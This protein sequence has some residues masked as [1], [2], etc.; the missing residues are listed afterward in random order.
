MAKV[1]DAHIH[2]FYGNKED[3]KTF[4]STSPYKDMY[5]AY[6][7]VNFDYLNV[8]SYLSDIFGAFLMPFI[9][10]ETD[11]SNTNKTLFEYVRCLSSSIYP[12]PLI[13]EVNDCVQYIEM[14]VGAKEH[15]I[16]HNAFACERRTDAYKHLNDHE[17]FLILH[18]DDNVRNN[19][20]DYLLQR[21]D[22]M[23]IILAHLGVNRRD[24]NLTLN[25]L[26][27]FATNKR[28]YF[29]T[30]TIFDSNILTAACSIIPNER[31]LFGSDTPFV[32]KENPIDEAIECIMGLNLTE[33]E[34]RNILYK[35]AQTLISNIK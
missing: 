12:V 16:K 33:E 4:L 30:S 26:Q 22:K 21:Y 1:F 5:F 34:K 23:K 14:S 10:K 17:K 25:T 20:V 13:D 3:M 35:N 11:I 9:L 27:K 7:S 24:N 32:L 19:Y 28:V 31:I 15:F 18:C 29:D 8:D 2:Y 6:H